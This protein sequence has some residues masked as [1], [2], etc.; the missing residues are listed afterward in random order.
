MKELFGIIALVLSITGNIPYIYE[1]IK[2]KVR[3]ERI[4][5]LLWTLLGATYFLTAVMEDGAVLFTAG[6]LFGPVVIFILALK[7]GVG[8]KSRFD[9]YSL[10]VALVA[11]VLLLVT[12]NAL[13]SLL[14]ALTVDGIGITLT[15]RKL[16]L[17]P[18]SESK[19]TWGIWFL[20]G[21]FAL[22]SL[23]TFTAETLLY[24]VYLLG[25]SLFIFLKSD[26]SRETN[27]KKVESL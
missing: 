2:G 13:L 12:K 18:A 15:I 20:S 8:G 3:P 1:T 22:L 10:M 5:W 21:I 25:V 9:I 6:E 24:P 19:T 16:L 14:L 27:I 4:S 26:S 11:F 17:D 7:F 23:S